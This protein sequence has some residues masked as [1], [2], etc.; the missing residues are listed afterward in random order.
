MIGV[1]GRDKFVTI[2]SGSRILRYSKLVIATGGVPYEV[3]CNGSN[4]VGIYYLRSYIDANQIMN[5][6]DECKDKPPNIVI[7]GSSFI[8]SYVYKTTTTTIY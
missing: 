6:I 1:D 7:F 8:G 3:Y 5:R 2:D 4:L